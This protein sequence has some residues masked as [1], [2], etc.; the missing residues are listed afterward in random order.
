MNPK[1]PESGIPLPSWQGSEEHEALYARGW[2]DFKFNIA[3][4]DG[5]GIAR[6]FHGPIEGW[7]ARQSAYVRGW[8]RGYQEKR[9]T[10][11]FEAG[12]K[13]FKNMRHCPP[14]GGVPRDAYMAGYL[15]EA[16]KVFAGNWATVPTPPWDHSQYYVWRKAGNRR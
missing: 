12:V 14:V 15:T 11:N 10:L 9:W 2:A 16:K 1:N 7:A 8:W 5:L 13:D 3:R 6:V 4:G